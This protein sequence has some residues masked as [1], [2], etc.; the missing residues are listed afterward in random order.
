MTV[1]ATL[2]GLRSPSR[3]AVGWWLIV[4][5]ILVAAMVTLGG[6]TRHTGSGLSIT[7]WKPVTEVLPPLTHEAWQTVFAKYQQIPQYRLENRGMTL[8]QF[9]AIYWW[10]WTHRLLGRLLGVVFL[11]PF[12][13]FAATGAIARK[14]WPR[15][16]L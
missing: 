13:L 15:M 4:M 16:V 9:Q 8:D 5:A 1:A 11:V 7:E 6:L 10:E 14:D 3:R 2:T 12:L